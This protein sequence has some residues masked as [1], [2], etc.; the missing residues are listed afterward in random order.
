MSAR[1]W[2]ADCGMISLFEAGTLRIRTIGRGTVENGS[3]QRRIAGSPRAFFGENG[4]FRRGHVPDGGESWNWRLVLD[5][6]VEGGGEE[7]TME[8]HRVGIWGWRWVVKRVRCDERVDVR[9]EFVERYRMDTG[10]GERSNAGGSGSVAG[11]GGNGC[12]VEKSGVGRFNW[13]NRV[14]GGRDCGR[15]DWWSDRNVSGLDFRVIGVV[16]WS[17]GRRG[18][19]HRWLLCLNRL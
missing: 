15:G 6:R 9:L 8:G 18:R 12:S 11:V 13:E 14:V 19:D 16:G 10:I 17:V 5:R 4:D 7:G 3:L 1:V 2:V